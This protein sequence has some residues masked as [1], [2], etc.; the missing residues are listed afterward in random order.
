[1][2]T[3]HWFRLYHRIID[4]EKIRL[5]AFE[6]RWHFV[7]IC[8]LKA[9]GLLDEP[10]SS[11][12]DRKIAVKL[13]V[14]L[15]ELDE[16]KRRLFEV[17][18]VD[19]DMQPC[20]WDELQYKSDNSTERVRKFREKTNARLNETERNVSGMHHK[21][22]RNESVTRQ[23][24]D[25]DT[26]SDNASSLR[27]EVCSEPENSAP[28]SPT[29][30]ELPTVNGEMVPITAA[31]AAEWAEAF[32]AVNVHQQLA[33][34]RAWLN[35]NPKNRKT[36]A[37]MKRFV[38][39][40]LSRDQDRGGERRK[41]SRSP[42]PPQKSAFRQHQDAVQRELDRALGRSRDEQLTGHTFDL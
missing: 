27:S 7:A 8:C 9:D 22:T 37:G 42:P 15:R 30:I 29:V 33:S 2:S 32:P 1:M 18:L 40:W 12:K 36:R 17:G 20:A 3:P 5:L 21:T 38:V 14:Q 35:A 19:E 13:G 41:Q 24:T 31:E 39:S 25:T 28:A 6:D 11:L 16:I 4:D 34:M 23:E 26:D 10:E